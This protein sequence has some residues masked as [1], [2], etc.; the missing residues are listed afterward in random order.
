MLRRA[1][2]ADNEDYRMSASMDTDDENVSFKKFFEW[3][4]V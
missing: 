4:I 3:N 1:R 2:A